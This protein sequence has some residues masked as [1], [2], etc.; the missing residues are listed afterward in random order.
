MLE[1]ESVIIKWS[2]NNKKHY[3]DKGYIFT[4]YKEEFKVNTGDLPNGSN[5]LVNIKCDGCGEILT[6]VVWQSYKRY[7]K[8]DGKYYCQKCGNSGFE[9]YTSFYEWCYENLSKDLSDY[10]LSRW[11]YKLNIDKNGKVL[12]PKDICYSSHG[13]NNKGYWFKCLD[14]PEHISEQQNLNSFTSDKGNMICRQCNTIFITHPHLAKFFINKEDMHKYTKGKKEKVIMNCPNCGYEKNLR[15]H[16]LIESGF[17]CHRC[18]D[19]IPY[20][21]KFLF[22]ML[23]QLNKDFKSQLSKTIFD[24]CG[25]YKYDKYIKN[26]NCIIEI[27]GKQHYEENKNWKMSLKDVQINDNLKEVLARNNGISNYIVIDCRYSDMDWIK[28]NIIKSKLPDLLDFKEADI[29]WIKCHE[30]S[31]GSLVKIASNLW[32]DGIKNT[33][34]IADILKIHRSTAVRYLNQGFKMN[35]CEYNSY[36]ESKTN[37]ILMSE[38]IVRKIICLTTK[39]IFNSITEASVKYDLT[40]SNISR[41][42]RHRRPSAGNLSDGTK[43]IWMYYDEYILDNN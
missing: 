36:K 7:V 11:D 29:D 9:K 31:C 16:T 22:K 30:F 42:C 5:T 38:K 6:E 32:Q 40:V 2:R 4:R 14:H 33:K 21:E 1:T 23:E 43:L 18:S 15:I 26:I 37:L 3:K 28:N 12:S 41:C 34:E 39:E 24:W 20:P 10:I 13:F 25:N 35:W 27:H 17:G 19:G 8:E